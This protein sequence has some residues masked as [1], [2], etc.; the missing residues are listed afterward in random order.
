[1]PMMKKLASGALAAILAIAAL[2]TFSGCGEAQVNYTLSEDGTYYIV[3]G[4]SGNK[5]A[6]KSFIVPETYSE[7]GGE[8]L[9]VKEIGYEAFMSCSRLSEVVLHDGIVKI[10]DRAFMY[11]SFREITIPDSVT[12]IGFGAFGMCRALTEI[13]VPESVTALGPL[14]FAYCSALKKA[15]VRAQIDTLYAQVFANSMAS[16]GGNYYT[17]TSL[18][19]V[20]L[21]ATLRKIHYSAFDGNAITDIYFAGT[22]EQ[23]DEL[24]FYKL[25]EVEDGEE[26]ET[27]EVRVEKDDVMTDTV[28]VHFEVE[29]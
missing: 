6:L 26:G 12:Y 25:V 8:E 4:V 28:T 7:E 19:E 22:E 21:P 24:Y 17:N 9:P 29:F 27:E 20:Y 5:S 2:G 23:W 13:T 16:V 15:Y 3:S 11:C 14:S 18:T 10:G 1:M